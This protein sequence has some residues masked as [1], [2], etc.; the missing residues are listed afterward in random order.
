MVGGV[1]SETQRTLVAL[2]HHPLRDAWLAEV[3]STAS[4]SLRVVGYQLCVCVCEG[5]G[6]GGG[7]GVRKRNNDNP[8][9]KR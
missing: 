9:L 2:R 8:I 1:G 7:G 4:D 5:V 6:G 3:A